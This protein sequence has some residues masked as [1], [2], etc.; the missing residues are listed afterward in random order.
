MPLTELPA[1]FRTFHNGRPPFP[2]K[3]VRVP[4]K[5]A[6]ALSFHHQAAAVKITNIS[7]NQQKSAIQHTQQPSLGPANL[8]RGQPAASQFS[9]PSQG[10]ASLPRGQPAVSQGPTS[11]LPVYQPKMELYTHIWIM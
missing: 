2:V 8:P 9:Q 10:P 7:K 3:F 4:K 5:S 1:D 6:P 11:S